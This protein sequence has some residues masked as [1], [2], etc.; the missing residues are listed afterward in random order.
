M[1][2]LLLVLSPVILYSYFVP[3]EHFVRSFCN[4]SVFVGERNM[5]PPA[6]TRMRHILLKTIQITGGG[7]GMCKSGQAV[8][9]SQ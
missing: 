3:N 1:I 4:F 8:R 6:P 2:F 7:Q 9:S 5:F